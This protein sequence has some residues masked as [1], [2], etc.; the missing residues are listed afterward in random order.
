MSRGGIVNFPYGNRIW[1][2]NL[3]V[4]R[5]EKSPTGSSFGYYTAG[6]SGTTISLGGDILL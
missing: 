2:P 3:H 4:I 1:R 6:Q 5:V